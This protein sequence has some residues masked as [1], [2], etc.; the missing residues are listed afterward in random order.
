MNVAI[1]GK[2]PAADYLSLPSERRLLNLL[3]LGS[4][5]TTRAAGHRFI[6]GK[7]DQLFL[8]YYHRT[9]V[10]TPHVPTSTARILLVR[11]IGTYLDE[12]LRRYPLHAIKL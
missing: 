8:D 7:I 11:S 4:F 1:F 2:R 5:T 3:T 9:P 10:F 12:F 6:A